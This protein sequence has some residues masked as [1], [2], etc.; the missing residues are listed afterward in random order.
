MKNHRVI[1]AFL[2]L[3]CAI[4]S[5]AGQWEWVP[6]ERVLNPSGLEIESRY[7]AF[8]VIDWNKD[9][10]QDFIINNPTGL[11]YFQNTGTGESV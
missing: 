7:S 6:D 8:Q 10:W 2:V 11:T 5:F 1:F 4:F 3:F 9:G